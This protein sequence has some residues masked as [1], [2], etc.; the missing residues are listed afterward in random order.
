[1]ASITP[2]HRSTGTWCM[3]SRNTASA[4]MFRPHA[5]APG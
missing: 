5:A 4:C 2:A 1:M 3:T